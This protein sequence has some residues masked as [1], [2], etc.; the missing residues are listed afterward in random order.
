MAEFQTQLQ[1]QAPRPP[2]RKEL[3]KKNSPEGKELG[4]SHDRLI[5]VFDNTDEAYIDALEKHNQ[6]YIWKIVIFA[7][8]LKWK[9]ANGEE[10]KTFDEKIVILK[11]TGITGY[12]TDQIFKDVQNLTRIEGERVDFLS[13]NE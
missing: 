4:L 2:V 7:L 8:D 10:A 6:D 12:H 3:I 1:G 9:K 13:D 5:Q 11:S